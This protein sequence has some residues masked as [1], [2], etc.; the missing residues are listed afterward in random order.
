[1]KIKWI[2]KYDGKNL[3]IV[4]VEVGAKE[5]PEVGDSLVG[6]RVVFSPIKQDVVTE[7]GTGIA[8][9]QSGC[10]YPTGCF[11]LFISVVY[12]D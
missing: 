3:P 6:E 12:A 8:L 4:D 2:R 7:R 9:Y 1:M 11:N 5:L 10:K